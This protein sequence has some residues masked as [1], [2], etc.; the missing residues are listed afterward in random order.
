[1]TCSV[2]PGRICVIFKEFSKLINYVFEGIVNVRTV[3]CVHG[4]ASLCMLPL[5]LSEVKIGSR[6]RAAP[7]I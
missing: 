6:T 5:V 7:S 1:M 2:L 4:V 3:L